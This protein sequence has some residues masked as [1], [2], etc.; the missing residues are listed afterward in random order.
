MRIA[1]A[2]R[3]TKDHGHSHRL[4]DSAVATDSEVFSEVYSTAAVR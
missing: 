3:S 1:M 2:V 4:V